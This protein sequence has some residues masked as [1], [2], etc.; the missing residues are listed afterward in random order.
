MVQLSTRSSAKILFHAPL[1]LAT[2]ELESEIQVLDVGAGD[3]SWARDFR[4]S[5][6]IVYAVDLHGAFA[7]YRDED[8]NYPEKPNCPENLNPEIDDLD[9]EWTYQNE[10]FHFIRLG[11]LSSVTDNKKGGWTEFTSLEVEPKDEHTAWKEW[12]DLRQGIYD[13]TGRAF[14]HSGKLVD[15]MTAAGFVNVHQER[16]LFRNC[17]TAI[18]VEGLVILP[19]YLALGWV[20]IRIAELLGDFGEETIVRDTNGD[21]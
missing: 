5:N 14:D 19:L 7:I 8:P 20:P 2:V 17:P 16:T 11:Q 21:N 1:D 18:D 12:M 3:G 4:N 15:H 13:K 9:R 10:M 6:A